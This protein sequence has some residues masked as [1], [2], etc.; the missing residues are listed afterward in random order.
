[1]SKK[2]R[3]VIDS[4]VDN[5]AR[6]NLS[7]ENNQTTLNIDIDSLTAILGMNSLE[8]GKTFLITLDNL[9]DYKDIWSGTF[10]S[11]YQFH[12]NKEIEDTTKQDLKKIRKRLR[13]LRRLR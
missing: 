2:I 1:M 5:L 10:D 7:S 3:L 6:I 8:E 13:R 12:G 4:I 11:D 9:E